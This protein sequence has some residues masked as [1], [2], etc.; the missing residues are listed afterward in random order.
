MNN[1][2]KMQDSVVFISLISIEASI[3]SAK[4]LD[5]VFTSL[6]TSFSDQTDFVGILT[7][8]FATL[9]TPDNKHLKTFYL[10]IPALTINYIEKMLIVKD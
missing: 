6:K 1:K 2:P 5:D 10:I 3:A 7:K 4:E 8:V 9:N